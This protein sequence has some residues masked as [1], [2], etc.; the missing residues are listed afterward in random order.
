MRNRE[1]RHDGDER[2]EPAE[3]NHQAQQEQQVIDAVEDV[4]ESE[5]DELE[6][7]L[8]PARIEPDD[9]G[10]AEEFERAHRTA[11]R[12]EAEHGDGAQSKSIE[13][14]PDREARLIRLNRVLE[15]D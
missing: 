2:S 10:I 9:S 6:R 7:R 11:W 13:L 15:Q 14:Q 4:E 1:R 8:M 3:R 5:L 12:H